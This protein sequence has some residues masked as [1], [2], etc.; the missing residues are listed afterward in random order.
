MNFLSFPSLDGRGF[1]GR[2]IK[3]IVI[4]P[5]LTLPHQEGGNMVLIFHFEFL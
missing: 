4:T 3:L 2:V 5:T 1:K